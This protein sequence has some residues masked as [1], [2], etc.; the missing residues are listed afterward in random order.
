MLIIF[1]TV[2][3]VNLIRLDCDSSKLKVIAAHILLK[4]HNSSAFTLRRVHGS[5]ESFN[6]L[7]PGV[8]TTKEVDEGLG[9][10]FKPFINCLLNFQFAL[11]LAYS[12]YMLREYFL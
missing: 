3:E 9:H 10:D 11:E 1:G 4:Y 7:F 5:L 8:F 2:L 12:A 6:D